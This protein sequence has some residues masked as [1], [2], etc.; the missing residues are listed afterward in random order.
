MQLMTAFLL[1]F[2]AVE[3]SSAISQRKAPAPDNWS[4]SKLSL[5][6]AN[7]YRR[8]NETAAACDALVESLD[9]YRMALAKETGTPLNDFDS[10]L[11]NDEGMRDVRS[12]FGCTR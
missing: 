9:H 1:T 5:R 8:I 3:S 2:A 6:T 4:E 11:G 12:Q 10:G 7:S